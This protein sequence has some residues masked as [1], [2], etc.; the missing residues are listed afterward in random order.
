VKQG[1]ASPRQPSRCEVCGCSSQEKALVGLKNDRRRN[2]PRW[3]VAH[4]P[5]FSGSDANRW[6]S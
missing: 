5:D 2:G 3:C 4:H 6:L 1:D